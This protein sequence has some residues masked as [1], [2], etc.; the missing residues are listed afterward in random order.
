M[1]EN[2]T[3][4]DLE[5]A[6][7]ALDEIEIPKVSGLKPNRMD[8]R[9][10]VKRVDRTSKLIEDYYDINDPQDVE[11]AVEAR[12]DEIAAAKLAKIEKIVDLDA[13]SVDDIQ[14]SYVGKTIIQC[15]Q[16]LTL[17]YKDPE[18]IVPSED[19]PKIVNVEEVCQHCGND[20]GYTIVG[21]VAEEEVPVEEAPVDETDN[22]EEVPLDDI[23][24]ETEEEAPAEDTKDVELDSAEEVPVEEESE[25]EEV[26]ESLELKESSVTTDH[27]D[28]KDGGFLDCIGDKDGKWKVVKA[29]APNE[30]GI[31]K[32]DFIKEYP[33]EESA[34]AAWNKFAKELNEEACIPVDLDEAIDT[35]KIDAELMKHNAYIAYVQNML[36]TDQ[37]ALEKA[38]KENMGPEVEAAIQRRIDAELEDLKNALPAAVKDEVESDS[39]PAADEVEVEEKPVEEEKTEEKPVEESCEKKEDLK[40]SYLDNIKNPDYWQK[41]VDYQIEKFGRVGGGLIQDLDEAG[42]YLDKDNKIKAKSNEDNLEE[43]TG[44]KKVEKKYNT[45]TAIMWDLTGGRKYTAPGGGTGISGGVYPVQATYNNKEDNIVVQANTEDELKPAIEIAKKYNKE[46][47][48]PEKQKYGKKYE[49]TIKTTTA[50]YEDGIFEESLNEAIHKFPEIGVD[51]IDNFFKVCDKIGIKTMLDLQRFKQEHCSNG[52]DLLK[53]LNDYAVNELGLDFEIKEDCENKSLTEDDDISDADFEKLLNSEEF[54]EP[55]SEEEVEAYLANESV[56]APEVELN[57]LE[58]FDEEL[59]NEHINKYLKEVYSNVDS[60]EA[61]NCD[62]KENNK[63]IVEGVVKFNSGKTRPVSFVF[64]KVNNGLLEGKANNINDFNLS[65]NYKVENKKF[66]TESLKYTGKVQ[67]NQVSGETK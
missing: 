57:E 4:F 67:D 20:T 51:E 61:T 30:N 21:K 58:D 45:W 50:D 33:D 43:A 15:P 12:D 42:F 38:K 22:T 55:I 47:E 32:E 9:E 14:P 62:V 37:K 19:D 66:I 40:E 2:I 35:K 8:I 5:Q 31:S 48:G 44:K 23:T 28:L 34:R 11:K 56:E 26:K 64:N 3:K 53:A 16:C 60:F 1:K 6:F 10:S 41:Q 59:F 49:L 17:F 25:E 29:F 7:K 52:E 63:F 36:A 27:I 18:D 54:K 24:D 13:E 65:L 39:L 46:F